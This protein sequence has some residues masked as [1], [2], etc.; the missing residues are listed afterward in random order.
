MQRLKR[1]DDRLFRDRERG[2]YDSVRPWWF[3][4]SGLLMFPLSFGVVLTATFMSGLLRPVL[5]VVFV[6]SAV[7]LVAAVTTWRRRHRM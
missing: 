3:Y 5:I 2:R 6:L 7:G 4:Y 1:L